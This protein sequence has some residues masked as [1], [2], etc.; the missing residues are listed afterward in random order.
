MGLLCSGDTS[1]GA[2]RTCSGF[3]V[4]PGYFITAIHFSEWTSGSKWDRGW[5]ESGQSAARLLLHWES[6]GLGKG[7][8]HLNFPPTCC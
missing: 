2:I 7:K 4:S 8:L 3:Q 6:F 5:L 1:N